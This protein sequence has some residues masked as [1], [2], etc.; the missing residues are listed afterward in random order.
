M[1]LAKCSN[2]FGQFTW[3]KNNTLN[4]SDEKK[5]KKWEKTNYFFGSVL[6][7]CT[8]ATLLMLAEED[9]CDAQKCVFFV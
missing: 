8:N 6:E 5:K 9:S 2:G 4:L 1:F 7:I 3:H